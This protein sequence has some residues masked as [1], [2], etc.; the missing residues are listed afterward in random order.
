VTKQL[1]TRLFWLVPLGFYVLTASRTPGWVDAPLI[2]KVVHRLELSIWVNNHNLFTLLGGGWLRIIPRSVDPHC[3]LN[4]LCAGL[5][6]L[7]VYVVFL[8]GL[9]L[10]HNAYASGLG[11]IVLMV[12]HSLWWHSAMLEVYT[13]STLLM[14]TTVLFVLRYEQ[15]GKFA[16]LC[17]AAF[18]FGLA[19]SNHVQM[20][21]LGFGFLG[22]LLWPDAR[23]K[24]LRPKALFLLAVCFLMGFQVYL[25][26]FALELI[27]RLES[28]TEAETLGIT[29]RA[30]LDRT[31]GGDF[32]Q[33]MFP[34]GLSI[35]ERLFWW[36]FYLG[37][38]I[39]NFPPPWILFVPV[40]AIAWLGKKNFRTS[41]TF[42]SLALLAQIVWS[43]NYFV[44][45]MYA[46]ALPA[47]VMT[48]IL[49]ILGVDW[50]YRRGAQLRTLL[51]AL[52]PT[53]LLIPILYAKA[54][55]WIA[56]S[57]QAHRF[58]ARIPQYEQAI[59]FWDPLE[60]FFNPNKRS[61]DRVQRY[62][63]AILTQLERGACYWGNEATMFYPL[64]YY[65]QDVLGE[66]S[67]VSYHLVFGIVESE[68][69]FKYHA[70]NLVRHL[71]RGCPVYVSSLGYPERNVLN[72]VYLQLGRTGRLAEIASLSESVFTETFPDYRFDVLDVDPSEGVRI[73]RLEER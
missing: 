70:A 48:G 19:C 68:V 27:E 29:L 34:A 55:G 71:R 72:H 53:V 39:Y 44:W 58:L 40:G 47:Y 66:R 4:L 23:R 15:Q 59:A 61:Y 25:W 24:I 31:S 1:L 14:T 22:L 21:L 42:F 12:S 65:Y 20:G 13:L 73:Y 17:V 38:F 51:Y 5:G 7:T 69:H 57:E 64:K 33:Y 62:S 37:F 46:F 18:V 26:V 67:D 11:A 60:Y 2:A 50:V 36:A 28:A 6:A 35:R 3:A 45:D 8:I 43:A 10:T 9:R 32:R 41:L 49:I 16:D 63:R 54:A 56:Q 52:T 30:M